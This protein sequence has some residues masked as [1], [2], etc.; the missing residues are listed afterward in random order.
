MNSAQVSYAGLLEAIPSPESDVEVWIAHLD[1]ILPNDLIE[2][3][4][5]LDSSENNRAEQF[6]F[7]RDRQPYIATRGLLRGLLGAA[8]DTPPSA[9]VFKY[10]PRGKP[11]LA[12]DNG[13][14]VLRFNVSHVGGLAIFATAW[15]RHLGID[16]EAMEHLA[17]TAEDLPALAMRV[18]S[19]R[20]FGI[21]RAL[22]DDEIRGRAL[23]RAWT[24]KE[25][26]LKATGEGLSDQLRSIEIALDAAAPQS[27]LTMRNWT[28]YDV[29]APAGFA[30]ALAVDRA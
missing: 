28:L 9:L 24:R 16:L 12:R 20:E 21:W 3:R 6:H 4:S 19:R 29:P 14:G 5:S 2:L 10:G 26:F 17:G 7:E 23:L 25:A 1:S 27:S 15:N 13:N 11:E 8:L 30:A 22:P 18:L